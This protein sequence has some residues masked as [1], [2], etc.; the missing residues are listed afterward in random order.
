MKDKINVINKF[1]IKV[2]LFVAIR[3]TKLVILT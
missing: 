3:I 1:L 2:G